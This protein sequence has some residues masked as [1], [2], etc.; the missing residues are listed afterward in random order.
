MES[1]IFRGG[2][3]PPRWLGVLWVFGGGYLMGTVALARIL[4]G[5]FPTRGEPFSIL[6]LG[7]APGVLSAAAALLGVQGK[8]V[9]SAILLTMVGALVTSLLCAPVTWCLCALVESSYA[10]GPEDWPGVILF[11]TFFGAFIG[12]PLGLVFGAV[13]SVG[14][15]LVAAL[16]ARAANASLDAALFALGLGWVLVG[17]GTALFVATGDIASPLVTSRGFAHDSTLLWLAIALGAVGLGVA[18][19]GATGWVSRR[20]LARR[21]RVGLLA[22]WAIVDAADVELTEGL[23]R[24]FPFGRADGVLLRRA[25]TSRGPFRSCE[26]STAVARV[27]V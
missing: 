10:G 27:A 25:A 15:S 16:R 23:P 1:T 11:V 20:W 18:I 22:G 13:F 26:P 14:I 8:R 24:L 9:G 3:A 21:A 5:E 17:G 12:A 7:L 2:G 19:T 6:L 4:G